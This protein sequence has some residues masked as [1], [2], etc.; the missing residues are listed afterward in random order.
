MRFEG[1]RAEHNVPTHREVILE[2][3]RT[4]PAGTDD[5]QL[6]AVLGIRPR[7]RV[8][9]I[10]RQ[11]ESEALV[12]R[13][14]DPRVGKIVN[15]ARDAADSVA[16]EERL[17]AALPSVSRHPRRSAQSRVNLAPESTRRSDSQGTRR[18][19]LVSCVKTKLPHTAPARDLYTSP[20][21]RKARAWAETHCDQWYILSALYGLVDPAAEI[22]PY[23]LTLNAM[24]AQQ[25]RAWV[26][27]V[28][29]R[30]GEIGLLSG[31]VEFVWLAG[32]VYKA[33]LARLLSAWPQE[34]P[35]QGMGIGSRMAWLSTTRP[36][37]RSRNSV[38]L[39]G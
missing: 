14:H 2:Y 16:V 6:S 18:V 4:H 15:Y 24:D 9:Q 22:A 1:F 25:R 34:D 10:A 30:M 13:R 27:R 8:N 12:L 5:D 23:E 36:V 3:L 11:L 26:E 35:L 33:D 17:V 20:L 31:G 21:F 32:R 28:Y 29:L 39:E 19:A 7:Q 37:E 38:A